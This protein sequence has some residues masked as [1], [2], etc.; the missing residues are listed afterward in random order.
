MSKTKLK[1]NSKETSYFSHILLI[2]SVAFIAC[3]VLWAYLANIDEVTRADGKVIPSQHVQI[4][5]NL[6]GGIVKKI[7]V[8]EG[9]IVDK[10]Q[11]LMTISDVRFSSDYRE[12]LLEKYSLSAKIQRL[13]AE[14]QNKPFKPSAS[15]IKEA[16]D[17]IQNEILLFKTRNKEMEILNMRRSLLNKELEMTKP[18]VKEGAVSEVEVLRLEQSLGEIDGTIITAERTTI[19]ELTEAKRELSKVKQQ[20]QTLKD[21][22][23]RTTVR[24][25]VKGI[26]K[27]IYVTT[28]GGVIQPGMSLMEVVPL[29]DTLLIEAKVRPS[30]IGFLHPGQDVMVKITAYDF[31]IY[32]G[33]KGNIE[34]ISADT[35]ENEE[36][37]SFYEV[38]V[39]TQKNFLGSQK[40]PLRIIPGMTSTVDVLTGEKSVLDYIMKPILKAKNRALR[41]R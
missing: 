14:T 38:W 7:L 40:G 17:L 35:T 24:S 4:V 9:E 3:A 37:D 29:D 8:R 5:Q 41:E 21:R 36:G 31:S 2:V 1:N 11:I 26:I 12:S 10:G 27:Q 34:H 18:L 25:P 39:R 23:E 30:D 28:I 19:D 16:P 15:L 33:L 22:L 32:G 13:I 20:N 6:E